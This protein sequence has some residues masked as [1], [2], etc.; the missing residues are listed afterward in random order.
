MAW[1]TAG[2]IQAIKLKDGRQDIYPVYENYVL[3][4]AGNVKDAFEK[5]DL[6]GEK[7]S[8]IDDLLT[9]DDDQPAEMVY[10]GVRKL[11]EIHDSLSTPD[12]LHMTRPAHG[13]EVS[14]SYMEVDSEDKLKQLVNRESV[15]VTYI[16]DR[17]KRDVSPSFSSISAANTN[18]QYNSKGE[19]KFKTDD[20]KRF[21]RGNTMAWYTVSLI[22]S[23]KLKDGRQKIYP[24][25]E[26]YVLIEADTVE[27]AFEKA[28]LIGEKVS[29]ID[30]RLILNNKPA[31][32]MYMGLRKLIEIHDPL[33]ISDELHMS[34]P[35]HGTEVSYS[36]M[37]VDS[38]D[39]LKR[40]A[41]GESVVITYID[42]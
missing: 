29:N 24:I 3:I 34:R 28:D 30:A 2:I 37:E 8:N 31:K 19:V 36:Y 18:K 17:K 10:M 1:Y 39:K 38:E 27:D 20:E 7:V 40:L 4:E 5:A 23:I 42:Y 11:I 21:Y 25:Y 9:L 33:S 6:I 14:Y 15:E 16:D 22:R 41:K 13:T 35:E 32:M 26:N 12:E